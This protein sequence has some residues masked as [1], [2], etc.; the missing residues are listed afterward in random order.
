MTTSKVLIP[1]THL[2][3]EDGS[4]HAGYVPSTEHAKS[5]LYNETAQAGHSTTKGAAGVISPLVL[6]FRPILV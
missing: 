1:P 6:L 5:F 4:A 2:G 3:R